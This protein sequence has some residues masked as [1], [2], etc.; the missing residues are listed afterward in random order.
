MGLKERVKELGERVQGTQKEL[1]QE[2]EISA[3]KG[4]RWKL[5]NESP[6]R[7]RMDFWCRT[8]LKDFS[9]MGYKTLHSVYDVDRNISVVKE[10]VSAWYDAQCPKGHLMRRNLT[11]PQN[12]R[13]FELSLKVRQDRELYADAMLT[14]NDDRFKHVYPEQWKELEAKRQANEQRTES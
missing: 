3:K 13:Y 7:Q 9:A 6:E 14:P 8:C 12:D 11:D 5:V 4:E 1:K 10:P 2:R